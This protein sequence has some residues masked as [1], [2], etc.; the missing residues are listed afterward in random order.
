MRRQRLK[1][2]TYWEMSTT[3]KQL[4]EAFDTKKLQKRVEQTSTRI[5]RIP[6]RG[7]LWNATEQPL[8][9]PPRPAPTPQTPMPEAM[10]SKSSAAPPQSHRRPP[11][12]HWSAQGAIL[13]SSTSGTSAS[14]DLAQSHTSSRVA[15]TK[16]GHNSKKRH[17]YRA[18]PRS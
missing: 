16:H 15:C 1:K 9:A 12:L 8:Q 2:R 10:S 7:S 4:L 3:E 6:F 14:L 5:E 17:C 13:A 11:K 18:S